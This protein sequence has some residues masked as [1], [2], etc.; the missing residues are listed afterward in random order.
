MSVRDKSTVT[1]AEKKNAIFD[2]LRQTTYIKSNTIELGLPNSGKILEHIHIIDLLLMQ[3]LR[4]I[5]PTGG[6]KFE[7]DGVE[8]TPEEEL[9][10]LGVTLKQPH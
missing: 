10:K 2:A 7:V 4:E 1:N 3:A 9:R 5:L 6:S 8:S